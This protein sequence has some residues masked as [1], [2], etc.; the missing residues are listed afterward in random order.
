MSK[1][2]LNPRDAFFGGRTENIVTSRSVMPGEEIKYTDICSLYPYI[3]KRGH[4]LIGHPRIYIGEEC[5]ALTGGQNNDLS[6]VEGIVKCKVLP[7]HNLLLPVLHVKMHHRLIF[8]LCLM[9]CEQ[10][11]EGDCNHEQVAECEFTGTRIV[12]EL[13][14][15]VELGYR[16]TEI[17]VIWE[18]ETTQFDPSTG[19]GGLFSAYVNTFLH[20]KQQASGWPICCIDE[21]SR[22]GTLTST[23]AT[24]G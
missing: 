8:G 16:A 24:R 18:Y 10:L 7:P 21:E 22:K 23:S 5:M 2:T 14:K 17:Y 13:Q 19:E 11:R 3:C 4:Y 9:C 1:I 6:H 20:L 15:A 12:D